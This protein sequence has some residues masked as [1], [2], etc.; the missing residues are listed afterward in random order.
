MQVGSDAAPARGR[1]TLLPLPGGAGAPP[2]G[3][4]GPPARSWLT[5]AGLAC[6]RLTARP[7]ARGLAPENRK[8]RQELAESAARRRKK[9]P[10]WRAERRHVPETVRDYDSNDAPLGAPSPRIF[11]GGG[12]ERR[13]TRGRK[14]YGRLVRASYPSPAGEGRRA[15]RSRVGFVRD[16]TRS[17][18]PPG[19][20][21]SAR[22][23]PSPERRG[24][25]RKN[26]ELLC[27]RLFGYIR[28]LF[29]SG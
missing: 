1:R 10:R 4:Y 19:R 2:G 3:Y 28:A 27:R 20:S 12:T 18:A 5:A 15:Q 29:R 8:A 21:R 23:P 7:P 16:I 25:I 14:E 24:G 26:R 22:V 9:T 13:P 11:E 17:C 6:P